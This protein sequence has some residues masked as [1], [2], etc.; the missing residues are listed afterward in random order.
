MARTQQP[1]NSD[2]TSKV[3][4]GELPESIMGALFDA[5]PLPMWIYDL[6]SL[7]FLVVNESAVTQYGYSR[8]E[9]LSMTIAE[10]RPPADVAALL[11]N[12]K[13]VKNGLNLAG[14]WRHYKK[15]G[16]MIFVEITS[17][18]LDFMDQR[19]EL[20]I[21]YDVSTRVAAETHLNHLLEMESLITRIS[22][23]LV[24]NDCLDKTIDDALRSIGSYNA[25]SRAYLFM[26]DH[27]Q[28]RMSNTHEWCNAGVEAKKSMLQDL[29][30]NVFPWSI[31]QILQ[32]L[33]LT[34]P[35]VKKL[36]HEAENERNILD[37]QDIKSLILVPVHMGQQIAGFMGFDNVVAVEQWDQGAE[38]MLEMAAELIG[39]AL[40]RKRDQEA[41]RQNAQ[42]LDSIMRSAEHFAFYR[43]AVDQTADHGAHV[44][45]A[46]DSLNRVIGVKKD[47]DF[48]TW[49]SHVHPDDLPQLEAENLRATR[50]GTKLDHTIRMFHPQK[51]VWRWI[52][53]VSNP[54]R[55][56]SGQITHYNGFL[57]DVT[58]MVEASNELQAERDFAKAVMDTVGAL[59]VVMDSTG[60]I[61]QYNRAC[62]QATGYTFEEVQGRYV[63]DFLLL[64][65]EREQVKQVF[66]ELKSSPISNQFENYWLSKDGRELLISWSNT[67]I[68]NEQG[69]LVYGIGT[70]IDITERK[71][72]ESAIRKLSSAV[73]QTANGIII[74]DQQGIMEYVNPAYVEICGL[75]QEDLIGKP[76]NFL[77]TIDN[78]NPEQARIWDHMLAGDNWRGELQ[79]RDKNGR[80]RW[81]SVTVSPIRNP[82]SHTTHFAILI[83]DITKLKHAHENLERLA[84]YDT[85][86]GL[87]NRR[88]FRDRLE[89]A[90]KMVHR[91]SQ[92]LALLYLDLD[93]FKKVNDS[94]GHDVGDILLCEVAKRLLSCVR[95]ADTVARLGGDEFVILLQALPNKFNV[96]LLARKILQCIKEPILAANQEV[97][98]TCSIGITLAPNDSTDSGTLLRN[99]DL[100]MY[101]SKNRGRDCYEYYEGQMN[102]VATQ[103]LSMEAELR[104]ALKT[105][106]LEPYFQPIVRLSDMRIVGFEALARWPHTQH[107]FISPDQFV[108]LAEDCGLIIPMGEYLL[109]R[110]AS[111]I[112]RIR[113]AHGADIY[114]AVNLSAS[115]AHD[116]NLVDQILVVL[117]RVH[118]PAKALRLEITESLLMKDFDMSR[119][120]IGHLREELG[121]NIAIDDFGTGYSSL[122]YLKRLPIDT[123]KVDRSFVADIPMDENDMEITPAIIAMAQALNKSVVAE[124]IETID[125]LDFLQSR[126]C[127]FGQGYLLG[128]P[129]RPSQFLTEPLIVQLDT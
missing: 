65:D 127:E 72:A 69:A 53:A 17:Y 112:L 61:V 76:P 109:E 34:I 66:Q 98:I 35:D 108:P 94:L 82:K 103:R 63:W 5:N 15:D 59:V 89:H 2:S 74:V 124:G 88:L 21:A 128:H 45:F 28:E 4:A 24:N 67:A 54:V 119:K 115:Q 114:V 121:T 80:H 56:A 9:F 116:S 50:T 68:L 100:A 123:L 91:N 75:S 47:A 49:F 93:N 83:E 86:T 16:S 92:Q 43:L 25:A 81:M 129:A 1:G 7:Q 97:V 51:Q 11:E 106:E 78:H 120:M 52:R 95:A 87:P 107:G 20:V 14:V 23:D 32:G 84:S 105:N 29:S 113:E 85:L 58:D 55:N 41:I 22:R 62:E 117:E 70:G 99:A 77:G 71:K 111:E 44:E 90:I 18:P 33:T 104:K 31:S 110:A 39:A 96:S 48:N 27:A 36:P 101:R 46:S 40:Q 26:I 13:Q 10:I 42:Q 122:S 3:S 79:Q 125:Q 6:K 30:T 38:R 126:G 64:P 73:D 12:V 102:R 60:V 19:A 118:L 57:L 8:K 37:Q